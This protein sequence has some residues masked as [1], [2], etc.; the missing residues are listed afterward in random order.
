MES[1]ISHRSL[2]LA[3]SL[4]IAGLIIGY[5]SV[6]FLQDDAFAASRSCPNTCKG[7]N[8]GEH[9]TGSGCAKDGCP[10]CKNKQE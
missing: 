6:V 2:W 5:T 1:A 9:C 10:G 3:V 4:V 8:C 7:E